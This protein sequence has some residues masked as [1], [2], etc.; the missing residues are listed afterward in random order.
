MIFLLFPSSLSL[1]LSLSIILRSGA[2]QVGDRILSINGTAT[3]HLTQAEV[4][5]LLQNA[6]NVVNL[7]IGFDGV[8]GGWT[9]KIGR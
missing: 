8:P 4:F 5:A 1:S 6:G 7:E 2:L 3:D 9:G